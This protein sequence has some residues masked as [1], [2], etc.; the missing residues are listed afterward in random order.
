[1]E[2]SRMPDRIADQLDQELVRE[3]GVPTEEI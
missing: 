2:V 1:M 3:F